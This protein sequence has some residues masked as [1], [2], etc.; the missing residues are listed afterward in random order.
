M[1]AGA[2]EGDLGVQAGLGVA[3]EEQ[4]LLL[5]GGFIEDDEAGDGA[6]GFG[7]AGGKRQGDG[8]GQAGPLAEVARGVEVGH[9]R[10][11]VRVGRALGVAQV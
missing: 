2:D 10:G 1:G 7:F 5:A 11:V 6:G 3:V 8:F 4:A 9:A